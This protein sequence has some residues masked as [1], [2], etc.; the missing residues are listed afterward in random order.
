MPFLPDRRSW[1]LR[2]WGYGNE[3]NA[4][5]QFRLYSE[6]K[7]FYLVCNQKGGGLFVTRWTL[8]DRGTVGIPFCKHHFRTLSNLVPFTNDLVEPDSMPTAPTFHINRI[9]IKDWGLDLCYFNYGKSVVTRYQLTHPED[10]APIDTRGH[11]Y[12]SWSEWTTLVSAG[13][14][15]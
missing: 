7:G 8:Q 11:H 1:Y 10:K 15:R 14:G 3:D 6:D 2:A 5:C 12:P 4:R 13:I 9:N